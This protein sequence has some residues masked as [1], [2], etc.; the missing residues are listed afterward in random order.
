MRHD[1]E[2]ALTRSYGYPEARLHCAHHVLTL[3]EELKRVETILNAAHG[4]WSEI[5]KLASKAG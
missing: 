1:A 5:R 3:L 2:L 4:D